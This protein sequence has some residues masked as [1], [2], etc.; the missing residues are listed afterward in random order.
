MRREKARLLGFAKEKAKKGSETI[1]KLDSGEPLLVRWQYGL[2]RVVSFLSDAK[3]RWSADWVRWSA[4][5]TLWPQVVR[6]V[7]HRDR[8]VRAGVRPGTREGESIVYY[9]VLGD[10]GIFIPL[11]DLGAKIRTE[12]VPEGLPFSH[13][14]TS[15][16]ARN[17]TRG[18]AGLSSSAN[19]SLWWELRVERRA[20]PPS[21]TAS[22]SSSG[23]WLTARI[24]RSI[25]K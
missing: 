21:R 13:D 5:G 19:R 8:T 23:T 4:Y 24:E 2:G 18:Q 25:N 11:T 9:D 20:E 10:S 16:A 17:A 6:D 1:L 14:A 3:A 12:A 7:S 15:L 22:R